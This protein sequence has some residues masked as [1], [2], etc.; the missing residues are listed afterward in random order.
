VAAELQ[1]KIKKTPPAA[2]TANTATAAAAPDTSPQVNDSMPS[3]DTHNE[4]AMPGAMHQQSF[5]GNEGLPSP[6]YPAQQLQATPAATPV[7]KVEQLFNSVRDLAA[8]ISASKI[9]SATQQ[10]TQ[11][12][13][14]QAASA[15][16]SQPKVVAPYPGLDGYAA[17]LAD[18]GQA[19]ASAFQWLEKNQSVGSTLRQL[20]GGHGDK[21]HERQRN[22]SYSQ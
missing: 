16:T 17:P 14:Q 8:G 22:K 15:F 3:A 7:S 4:G 12:L 18:P 13:V 5:S 10:F 2:T 6:A 21:Q 19:R 11:Q 9:G 1:L 20:F